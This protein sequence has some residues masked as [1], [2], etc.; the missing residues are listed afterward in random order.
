MWCGKNTNL[1]SDMMRCKSSESSEANEWRKECGS[2]NVREPENY[3][4]ILKDDDF[5]EGTAE[6]IIQ[7]KPQRVA[8]DLRAR[9]PYVMKV[10]Y[11]HAKNYPTDLYYLMDGSKSMEDDQGMLSKLG[12]V[13]ASSIKNITSDFQLGFGIFVEKTILP[14]I[15]TV[16]Y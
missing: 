5:S 7:L 9:D 6:G 14:Y 12:K 8:M 11:R 16:P 10:Q 13:L 2:V 15:T 4:E 1:T 3:Y